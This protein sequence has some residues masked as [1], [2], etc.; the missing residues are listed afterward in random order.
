MTRSQCCSLAEL[1]T[2][3]GVPVPC[4]GNLPL[5]MGDPQFAWFVEEGAVDLFLVERRDGVELSAPQHLLRAASG[6]LLPGVAPQEEHTTLSLVAKGLPGTVLRRLPADGLAAVGDAEL[7]AQV[8]LW[9]AEVSAILARDVAYRPPADVLVEAGE[10]PPTRTGTIAARHGVVWVSAAEGAG[11]FMGLIDLA[12]NGPDGDGVLGAVPLTPATWLSL[13]EAVRLSA[14]SSSTLAGEGCLLSALADFHAMAFSLE[15]LNRSL[16]AVDQANLERARTTNR[17]T[18]EDSARRH[19]FDLYGLAGQPIAGAG[20]MALLEALEIIGRH[21]GVDFRWPAR[22]EASDN[23]A[24]LGNV[25]DAS[26]VRARQVRLARDDKWWIGSSG[27]MLAFRVDDG[28]PV[29]LLPSVSGRYRLV[30]P[31]TRRSTRVTAK[32]AE[33]LRTDAWLFYRPLTSVSAGLGELLR[34]AGK[35]LNID[36]ARFVMAGLFNGLVMLLPAL[37]LGFVADEAIPGGET[38]PLYAATATL[39]MVAL[40]GALL[41]VLQGMALMRLEGH[42]AS[43][44]EAAF[45]DRLLRLPPNVWDL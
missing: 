31:G 22:M 17:R 5:D 41:L 4:A 19:L 21:E 7:A 24:V 32:R 12:K 45:W 30:D 29:A 13:T 2:E 16:A 25:L 18:D 26:G 11:L 27:A 20:K 37:V 9:L 42:V 35:G 33:T 40:L 23:A 38:G 1:A 43:R 36:L 28:R 6:R 14:Q 44:A 34:L 10:V 8:D 15:R 39:A 3:T